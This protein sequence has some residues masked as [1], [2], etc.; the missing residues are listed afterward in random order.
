MMNLHLP[1]LVRNVLFALIGNFSAAGAAILRSS[2]LLYL[3]EFDVSQFISP[4]L[5]ELEYFCH[6]SV[7]FR[8]GNVKTHPFLFQI[9]LYLVLLNFLT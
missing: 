1:K 2:S 5:V 3:K 9:A 7:G 4:A 6:Q 8:H